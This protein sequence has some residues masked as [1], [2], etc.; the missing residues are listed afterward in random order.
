MTLAPTSAH[1]DRGV[2][3]FGWV[4]L[5]A[6]FV[7]GGVAV[8]LVYEFGG[9][10]SSTLNGSGVPAVETRN[11]P[12][13]HAV[14]LAGA[15][16][17][18]I[19]VGGTQQV[20]VRADQ[21]LIGRVT[22]EVRSGTLVVGNKPGSYATK[23]PTGV[24]ITVPSLSALT[25]SGSGNIVVDGIDAQSLT[26]NLPGSGTLNG[27]GT[28]TRLEVT[29]GGSGSVQ[30]AGVTARDGH[31]VVSGSGTIFLNVTGSLDASVSGS[32]SVIYA[33][34][35]QTVTKSVTGSGS[36]VGG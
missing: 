3:G 10:S 33:G 21:N 13:F 29:I 15:N 8:A 23:A 2:H 9:S 4:L 28:V 26:V 34:S 32:G 1:P 22:T 30:F 5:L 19:H 12:A 35:P 31:A 24:E 14:E 16:N 17:V 27:S 7:L 20:V 11:V 36:I 18:A 25:L 6:A